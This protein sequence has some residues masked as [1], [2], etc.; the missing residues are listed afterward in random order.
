MA[1]NICKICCDYDKEEVGISTGENGVEIIVCKYC[2]VDGGNY[3]GWGDKEESESEEE[4][5]EKYECDMPYCKNKCE[6][7]IIVACDICCSL[8]CP[9]CN[10]K[11]NHNCPTENEEDDDDVNSGGSDGEDY[12]TNISIANY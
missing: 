7:D 1:T 2:D 8:V 3:N 6:K 9:E 12:S 4:E 11:R 10:E 5:E